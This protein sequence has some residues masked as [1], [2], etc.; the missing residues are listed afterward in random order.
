MLKI[1][2]R[3]RRRAPSTPNRRELERTT[4]IYFADSDMAENA[5]I[6]GDESCMTDGKSF[7]G[8]TAKFDNMGRII[9][10]REDLQIS[11]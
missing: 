2:K 6:A 7:R 4:D 8:T 5:G 10:L 11:G 9:P 1:C 3:R